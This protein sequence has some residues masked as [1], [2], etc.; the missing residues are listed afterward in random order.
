MRDS[1]GGAGRRHFLRGC[2]VGTSLNAP[3]ALD[4]GDRRELPRSTARQEQRGLNW[5]QPHSTVQP[6]SHQGMEGM[7]DL[8]WVQSPPPTS[9]TLQ[10]ISPPLKT[11]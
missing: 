10:C 3:R 5:D 7:W 9:H 11:L 2:R 8:S 4:L 1:Q 6:S